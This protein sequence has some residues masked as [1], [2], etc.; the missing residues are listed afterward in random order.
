L[1]RLV[2]GISE[3]M[4]IQSLKEL[5]ADGIVARRDF[6]EA[7]PH[8]AYTLTEFGQS[9]AEALRPLCDWGNQHTERIQSRS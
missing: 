8:V 2:A 6:Q 3:K 4:L 7:P 9:L 5:A 1:R